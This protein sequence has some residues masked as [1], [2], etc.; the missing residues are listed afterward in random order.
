MMMTMNEWIEISPDGR[1][2]NA[3]RKLIFCYR[4]WGKVRYIISE[5]HFTLSISFIPYHTILCHTIPYH[6]I[7]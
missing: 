1:I 2:F 5:S 4:G 6:T 7:P 3:G